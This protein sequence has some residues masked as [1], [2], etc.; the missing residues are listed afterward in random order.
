M[1]GLSCSREMPGK[2]VKTKK[3]KTFVPGLFLFV[4]FCWF[5][6]LK[7]LSQFLGKKKKKNSAK[8][9]QAYYLKHWSDDRECIGSDLRY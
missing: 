7:F 1:S 2:L 4:F 6:D 8:C 3:K 9:R 5:F